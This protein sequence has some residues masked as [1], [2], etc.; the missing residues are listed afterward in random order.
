RDL[1]AAV[2]RLDR[3]RCEPATKARADRNRRHKPYAIHAVID[4]H[5]SG[6]GKGA[7]KQDA[8]ERKCQKTVGDG[9]FERRLRGGFDRINLNPLTVVSGFGERV[10]PG[11]RDVEPRADGDL[12]TDAIAKRGEVH[13]GHVDDPTINAERA[14]LA[15]I[16]ISIIALSERPEGRP[17]PD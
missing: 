9:G 17:L 7:A 2:D 14:E 12:L 16:E 13:C 6:E 3:A 4:R 5:F 8:H 15:E 10:D 11:L 1:H